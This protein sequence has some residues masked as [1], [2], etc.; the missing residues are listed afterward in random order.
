MSELKEAIEVNDIERVDLEV[1]SRAA[2]LCK[3]DL[4]SEVVTEFPNL[5]GIIGY[6]YALNDGESEKVALAI[7]DHYLPTN[8]YD[9]LPETIEGKFLSLSDKLDSL[10][11][12]YIAGERATGSKDPMALRRTAIAIIRLIVEGKLNINLKDMINEIY[13]SF[14]YSVETKS[15]IYKFINERLIGYIE[16]EYKYNKKNIQSVINQMKEQSLENLFLTIKK[17]SEIET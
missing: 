6:H 11:V 1:L 10:I 4:V 17:I 5:Q 15:E 2:L 8:R 12:F 13:D 9:K 16:E 3:S 7:R 14:E